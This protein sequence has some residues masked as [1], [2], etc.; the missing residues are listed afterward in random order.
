MKKL[1]TLVALVVVTAASASASALRPLNVQNAYINPDEE[2]EVRVNMDWFRDHGRVSP[3]VHRRTNSINMPRIDIRKNLDT[4]IPT[5][6]GMNTSMNIGFNEIEA[7]GA[8]V[9]N[10]AL[11]FGNIGLTLEAALVNEEDAALTVYLNQHFAMLHN[12]LLVAGS[13]RPQNG[14]NGYGFQTGAEY[15]FN[16][17]DALTWYGDVG[18]R[19]DVPQ[20][21]E[22]QNSFIYWNELV[23]DTGSFIN[24][25]LGLLGTS[26]YND[27]LGT[28]LRLVPGWINT[29]GNDSEY[30][31]RVGFPIGINNSAPDFGV[32]LGIFAAL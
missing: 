9:E 18:Y 24:P 11:G 25:T 20:A 4:S 31:F 27:N 23:W 3:G 2:W 26:T 5:R 22:V 29:F 32:Q 16:V 28:D 7:G 17:T 12:S 13:L 21:G 14:V 19:F 15:Q 1:L 10:S 6:I 30:Q 8:E